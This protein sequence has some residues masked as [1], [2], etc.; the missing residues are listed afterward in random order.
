MR[1]EFVLLLA[2]LLPVLTWWLYRW[3]IERRLE[4]PDG[5]VRLPWWVTAP[6]PKLAAASLA[7]LAF[8]L[9]AMTLLNP[10]PRSG[11][12]QPAQLIDGRLVPGHVGPPVA[13]D[14]KK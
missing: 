2:L 4:R 10:A 1:R 3:A 11:L 8:A 13:G 6:W 7:L 9:V 5:Y 14:G 12:Y